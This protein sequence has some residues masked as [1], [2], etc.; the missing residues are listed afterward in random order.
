MLI[1]DVF[2]ILSLS[3]LVLSTY[4][5]GCAYQIG[6]ISGDEV[7]NNIDVMRLALMILEGSI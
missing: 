6:D 5:E 4:Q 7:V 3:D 1:G 2:D